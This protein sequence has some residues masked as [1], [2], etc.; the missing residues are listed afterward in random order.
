MLGL[1]M[2]HGPAPKS[3]DTLWVLVHLPDVHAASRELLIWIGRCKLRSGHACKC[4]TVMLRMRRCDGVS[5]P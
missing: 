1:L 2:R 5:E 3:L 4:E